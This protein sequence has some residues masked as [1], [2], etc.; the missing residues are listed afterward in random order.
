MRRES[1][2][3]ASGS[4]YALIAVMLTVV[5]MFRILQAR[6]EEE[7]RIT[8]SGSVAESVSGSIEK[9]P[10][11]RLQ[12]KPEADLAAFRAREDEELN[13]YGWI[14]R[15]A[16][17]VRIPIERAMDLIA[18]RGLPFR[19]PARGARADPDDPGYATGT[20]VRLEATPY[21]RNE[22]DRHWLVLLCV[23]IA[24]A[25][26]IGSIRYDAADDPLRSEARFAGIARPA[27]PR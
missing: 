7:D 23:L 26:A 27:L 22:T 2:L 10:G 13:H 25:R 1:G 18:Q 11:P 16:G 3:R 17:V 14:D 21:K 24:A 4:W 19:R 5:L 15:K 8:A 12:V 6:H 20:T 9:F